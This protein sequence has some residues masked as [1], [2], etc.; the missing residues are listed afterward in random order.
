MSDK[1]KKPPF[2]GKLVFKPREDGAW[3]AGLPAR[4]ITPEEWVALGLSDIA[5]V[6][7]EQAVATGFYEL[8]PPRASKSNKKEEKASPDTAEAEAETEA[9]NKK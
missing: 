5:N 8:K 6:T 2:E 9:D 1:E 4:D 7:P 3:V